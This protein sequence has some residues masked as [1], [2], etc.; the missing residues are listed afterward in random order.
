MKHHFRVFCPRSVVVNSLVFKFIVL[1]LKR[2]FIKLTIFKVGM[3]DKEIV[4]SSKFA[5]LSDNFAMVFDFVI[6]NFDDLKRVAFAL[7]VCFFAIF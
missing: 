4:S 5:R 2:H 6:S 1:S 3:T 7:E